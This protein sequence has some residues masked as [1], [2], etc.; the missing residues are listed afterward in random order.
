MFQCDEMTSYTIYNSDNINCDHIKRKP[1]KFVKANSQSQVRNKTCK[2]KKNPEK[3][4]MLLL[5]T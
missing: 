4:S 3:C 5:L 2:A 1:L